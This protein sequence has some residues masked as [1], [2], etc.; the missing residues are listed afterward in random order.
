MYVY[1]RH[2]SH[3]KRFQDVELADYVV[4]QVDGITVEGTDPAVWFKV[5]FMDSI[6]I[7]CDDREV[8]WNKETVVEATDIHWTQD[9][10]LTV[11]NTLPFYQSK[12]I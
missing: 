2:G 5:L 11:E 6:L 3:I 9:S 1:L 8:Y 12:G 7:D 10:D 4:P